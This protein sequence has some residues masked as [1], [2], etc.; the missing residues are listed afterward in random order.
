MTRDEFKEIVA[1][2]VSELYG[3][4]GDVRITIAERTTSDRIIMDIY[5]NGEPQEKRVVPVA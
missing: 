4:E 3:I 1:K 2:H 5:K